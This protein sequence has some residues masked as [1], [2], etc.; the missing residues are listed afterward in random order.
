MQHILI[1]DDSKLN[2]KMANDALK[3]YY[4]IS[5]ASSGTEALQFIKKQSVDLILLDFEM[6]V[7]NG[8]ETLMQM[9]LDDMV[10]NIPVIFLTGVSNPEI[11]SRCLTLGAQDFI[12]KPF[13]QPAMLQR[14]QRVLELTRLRADLEAQVLEKTEE[15]EILTVQ[16]ITTFANAIDAKDAY[17]KGHSQRVAQYSKLI[18]Q[19]L[20]WSELAIKNL[21]YTAILHDIGKIG[22]PDYILCKTT[23]LNVDEY[24]IIK[25]HPEIGSHILE[26]VIL[27]PYLGIGAYS[28]H[29]K[30]DGSGYPL[31]SVGDEIPLIGRIISVADAVDA[32]R[33]DRAYRNKMPIPQVISELKKNRGT[34][35]DPIITDIMIGILESDI[36]LQPLE[37]D[38]DGQNALLMRVVNEYVNFSN[39]DGLT[40]LWNRI[41]LEEKVNQYLENGDNNGAFLMIDLDDFKRINDTWGHIAG[42]SLL[43]NISVVIKT[44]LKNYEIASRMG[45]DEFAVYLPNVVS[46]EEAAEFAQNLITKVHKKMSVLNSPFPVTLSIGIALAASDGSSYNELY[47]NADKAL[48]YA[49]RTNKNKF[50]FYKDIQAMEKNQ[51]MPYSI[52]N[53]SKLKDLLSEKGIQ[54]GAYLVNRDEFEK[55]YQLMNRMSKRSQEKL[56]IV[57]FS[58]MAKDSQIPNESDL[59]EQI[60]NLIIATKDSLRIGDVATKFGHSQYIVL[61]KNADQKVGDL[62][63]KRI[64]SYYTKLNKD[65]SINL[66]YEIDEISPQKA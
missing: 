12:T 59:T 26:D 47:H 31:G 60:K 64:V 17:T 65:D 30:Y 15:L 66:C 51:L 36:D 16:T 62:V 57:L 2:L 46:F 11:E 63:V 22:I 21:F 41:Y 23:Q 29:E 45:G 32:M 43:A 58:F 39:I 28:H 6:P 4:R 44:L 42:D 38:L 53:L 13:F 40:G 20:N 14:V 19:K 54:K 48:Y 52:V 5:M 50:C 8:I 61:L 9:K 33:S 1:V 55:I 49:K 18:A 25:K 35:F 10:S 37:K 27:V 24:D 34:Q 3:D 7:L 56:Q